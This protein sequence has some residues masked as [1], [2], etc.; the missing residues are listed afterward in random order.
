MTYVL[1]SKQD[2]RFI[3]RFIPAFSNANAG[4]LHYQARIMSSNKVVTIASVVVL[5]A[6]SALAMKSAAIAQAQSQSLASWEI[7]GQFN[8]TK[9]P[10][11]VWTYGYIN[12][13]NCKGTMIPFKNKLSH[14]MVGRPFDNWMLG[15]TMNSSDLPHVSQSKDSTSLL[16]LKLSPNGISMHPGPQNQCAVVRF[17]APAKGTY[18]FMG[19][20]WAQNIGSP[21]KNN[22]VDVIVAINGM[23]MLPNSG[24]IK[25]SGAATNKPFTATGV[26]LLAGGT[27]DFK[28]GSSGNFDSD[29][30]GL[31][32]YIQRDEP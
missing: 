20:F 1:K 31:H 27:I 29:S 6:V 3:Y 8:A 16:P 19:R 7:A 9:N 32:G 25:A 13:A 11:E 5:G 21:N 18:R 12:E 30:T 14:T 10:F 24:K 26:S 23:T 28:V 4:Y 15:T 17:T 2:E 22:D